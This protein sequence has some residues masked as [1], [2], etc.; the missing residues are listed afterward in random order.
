M[1][2]RLI[3]V[4]KLPAICEVVV[5]PG[6]IYSN[7][8]VI[9]DVQ[10]NAVYNIADLPTTPRNDAMLYL[11]HKRCTYTLY[12]LPNNILLTL[13]GITTA[14]V[15]ID[16]YAPCGYRLVFHSST[17]NPLRVYVSTITTLYE[18]EIVPK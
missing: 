6:Q 3:Q 2:L 4:T 15:P 9:I 16:Y 13:N 14:T 17:E 12:M 11:K 7:G 5:V 18:L 8:N 10:L 1:S